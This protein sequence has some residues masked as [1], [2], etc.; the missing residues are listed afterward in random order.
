MNKCI[1]IVSFDVPFPPDYG[2]VLD[3]Y[4]RTK[5]LK[6]LGYY[7]IL[8]CYEYGRGTT[9]DFSEI[10]NEIHYYHREKG[11]RFLFSKTPFIVK[12]RNSSKLL[13]RLLQ[14]EH[15][16]LLE[17]QHTTYWAKELF[18]NNRLVAIRM[19]NIE[20]RYYRDLADSTHSIFNRVYYLLE[21][22][23]LKQHQHQ[24][25]RIPLLC[26]STNDRD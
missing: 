20:W 7:V 21:A 14:D 26:I 8:H 2:G 9:H 16:V 23:K 25:K 4:L 17:G 10:A 22:W 18:K 13:N 24:L 15:P 6:S 3:V 12:T 5:A 1:H 19:H 11:L